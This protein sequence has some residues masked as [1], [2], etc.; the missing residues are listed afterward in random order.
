MNKNHLIP[1]LIIDLVKKAELGNSEK[2]Q[3]FDSNMYISRIEA[4]RDYC[5]AALVRL[6]K[7]KKVDN[8]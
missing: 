1:E 4:I 2:P 5:N 6:D 7:K 3:H 8:R